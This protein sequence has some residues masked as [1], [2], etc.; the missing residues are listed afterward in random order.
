MKP[1]GLSVRKQIFTIGHEIANTIPSQYLV[2][3]PGIPKAL[4]FHDCQNLFSCV[5]CTVP[6][7]TYKSCDLFQYCDK[8]VKLLVE[9]L[10]HFSDHCNV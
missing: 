10:G 8:T 6:C 9:A 3:F 5:L 4:L 2:I 7:L 1:E